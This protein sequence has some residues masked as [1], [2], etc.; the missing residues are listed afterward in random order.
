MGL[1]F[2]KPNKSNKGGAA[3]FSFDS[4]SDKKGIFVEMIK[5]NG[6][7]EKGRNGLGN[8][9]FKD[10]KKAF[11]KFTT[12]EAATILDSI[13]RREDAPQFVHT[14][15][16]GTTNI[17]FK[18]FKGKVK[19]GND[20]VEA[21]DFTNYGLSVKRGE[22]QFSISFTFG[23]ATELRE[24]LKFALGHVFSG[25]YSADLQRAKEYSANKAKAE[26]NKPKSVQDFVE[27]PGPISNGD[28]DD[29]PF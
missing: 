2:Y 27:E 5:Q 28:E 12:T 25:L 6:W 7:D 17:T 11:V 8:G 23:E 9:V 13:E 26:G 24:Y 16:A 3:H 21:A 10:G 1:Q 4:R 20:W 22:E 15:Q 14:S 19:K 29:I 18:R